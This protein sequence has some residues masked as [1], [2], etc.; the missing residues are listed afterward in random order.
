MKS[1]GILFFII[2]MFKFNQV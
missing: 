1:E 2:I